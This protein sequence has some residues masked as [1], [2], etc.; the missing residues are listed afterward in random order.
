MK[1]D[2]ILSLSIS[3]VSVVSMV[4]GVLSAVV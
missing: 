1:F 3:V 2:A 4:A